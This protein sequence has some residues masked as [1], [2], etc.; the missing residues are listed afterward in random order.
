MA[1]ESEKSKEFILLDNI[2]H[3]MLNRNTNLG[4]QMKYQTGHKK[5]S[6]NLHLPFF[7]RTL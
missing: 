7:V 5:S 3:N 1:L 4:H 2:L 6:S